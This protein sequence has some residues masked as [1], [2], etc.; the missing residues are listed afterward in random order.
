MN[1]T[2]FSLLLVGMIFISGCKRAIIAQS[3]IG[4]EYPGMSG[5]ILDKI[6]RET[7]IPAAN[8]VWPDAD[9]WKEIKTQLGKNQVAF[10]FLY[11]LNEQK[12]PIV[13]PDTLASNQCIGLL[14]KFL[15]NGNSG[16][17]IG[18]PKEGQFYSVSD[19]SLV[20]F[21]EGKH[22]VVLGYLYEMGKVNKEFYRSIQKLAAD[23]KRNLQLFLVL[24]NGPLRGKTG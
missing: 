22:Y 3:E 8:I 11:L 15:I 13:I 4:R 14:E 21:N 12:V 20:R 2:S 16:Q 24:L 23:P 1:K 6:S 5:E 9:A 19:S 10:P 7:S 18:E 17:F